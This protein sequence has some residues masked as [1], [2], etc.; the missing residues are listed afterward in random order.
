MA[1]TLPEEGSTAMSQLGIKGAKWQVSETPIGQVADQVEEFRNY[2]DSLNQRIEEAYRLGRPFVIIKKGDKPL[3]IWFGDMLQH[4]PAAGSTEKG[5][6]RQSKSYRI[7]REGPESV[8]LKAMRKLKELRRMIEQGS[9]EK[10]S[11]ITQQQRLEAVDEQISRRDSRKFSESQSDKGITGRCA[12]IAQSRYFG[13]VSTWVVIFNS[14]WLGID[15]NYNH[16]QSLYEAETGF[17]V[18]ENVFCSWYLLELIIRIAAFKNKMDCFR[19][20]WIIFDAFLLFLMAGEIWMIPFYFQ[21]LD[22]GFVG[23]DSAAGRGGWAVLRVARLV[24]VARLG[25]LAKVVRMFPD[26]MAMCKA[27]FIATRAVFFTVVLLGLLVYIFAIIFVTQLRDLDI[28]EEIP[29]FNTM[30]GSMWVLMV[31]GILLDNVE[32]VLSALA[33]QTYV[34]TALFVA[35]ISLSTFTVLNM[36]IGVLCKVVDEVS[37]QEKD[38]ADMKYLRSTLL[39]LLHSHVEKEGEKHIRYHEFDMLFRNPMTEYVLDRFGVSCGDLLLLKDGLFDS[40]VE[41]KGNTKSAKVEIDIKSMSDKEKIEFGKLL[42]ED[43]DN[44]ADQRALYKRATG[45][46]YVG[47]NIKGMLTFDEVLLVVLR[48]RGSNAAKVTDMV[49]LREFV[50]NSF[51]THRQWLETRISG[52]YTSDGDVTTSGLVTSPSGGLFGFIGKDGSTDAE[53]VESLGTREPVSVVCTASSQIRADLNHVSDTQ[54][55]AASEVFSEQQ[56]VQ[57]LY[58]IQKQLSQKCCDLLSRPASGDEKIKIAQQIGQISRILDVP[59]R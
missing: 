12:R 42:E 33:E 59:M 3:E 1:K 30:G 44:T 58:E 53:A 35:W 4:D 13:F 31:N 5:N 56:T 50:K 52:K 45:K 21:L 27:I 46:D 32:D 10:H 2:E 55:L 24:K 15:A 9:F 54:G 36:L 11:R 57:Q 7:K 28:T 19:D 37:L 16:A 6:E 47:P 41:G 49:D 34:M 14:V 51:V 26:L 23:T 43:E 38:A 39:E 40:T 8:K 25:R 22:S 29:K 20:G 48:L 18:V 17:A